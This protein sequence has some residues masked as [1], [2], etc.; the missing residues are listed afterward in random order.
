MIKINVDSS[1]AVKE[2]RKKGI[3]INPSEFCWDKDCPLRIYSN[4][5]RDVHLK[6]EIGCKYEK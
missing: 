5:K 2:K 3:G 1:P 4:G 6:S